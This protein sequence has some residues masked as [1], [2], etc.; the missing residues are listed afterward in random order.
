[1]ARRRRKTCMIR[2]WR[3]SAGGDGGGKQPPQSLADAM[4]KAGS[5]N[6]QAEDEARRHRY[7]TRIN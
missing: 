4:A 1:M 6:Q 5:F 3:L 2:N 7:I